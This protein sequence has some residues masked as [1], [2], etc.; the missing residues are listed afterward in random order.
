MSGV[1]F[2]QRIAG[3]DSAP[4]TGAHVII[5]YSED[6]GRDAGKAGP[7]SI[8]API[9]ALIDG[10]GLGGELAAAAERIARSW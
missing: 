5:D 10:F 9:Q 1:S 2:L 6:L 8:V 3:A 7:I 4:T